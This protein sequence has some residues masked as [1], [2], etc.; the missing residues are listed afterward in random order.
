MFGFYNIRKPPGPTS[1]DIVADIR[2]RIGGKIK[3]GHAG[4]LDPFAEGVLVI[5]VASATRL[6]SYVQAAPKRYTAEVTLGATSAT[7]DPQGPITPTD[8]PEAPTEEALR[9]ALGG[10]VGRIEQVPPAHSAVHVQGRRAYKLARAGQSPQ[11]AGRPVHIHGIDL[12]RYDWPKLEIDVHCGSGTYIRALGRDIG[13]LL[14]VGGYCSAL[15][16]TRVGPF[17]I[18]E[19]VPIDKLDPQGDLISPLAA[20]DEMEKLRV[21]DEDAHALSLGRE[22]RSGKD[23]RTSPGDTE[24]AVI[25]GR[26]QLI[27]IAV[28]GSDSYTIRPKKVFAGVDQV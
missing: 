28:A 16:R 11:L 25:N 9:R 13:E 22:I 3:I 8:C 4:T 14:H 7:D 17:D 20:L 5:C 10:F 1:H 24:V 19:S 18:G 23:K 12:L 6:A 15:V 27:A 21:S 2:R 26:G